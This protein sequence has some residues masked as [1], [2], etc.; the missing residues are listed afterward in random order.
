MLLSEINETAVT[1]PFD[2]RGPL[3]LYNVMVVEYSTT[4]DW[5]NDAESGPS[6]GG[7]FTKA[8][9]RA[10]DG[11]KLCWASRRLGIQP[12]FCWYH[13]AWPEK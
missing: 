6:P 4:K 13:S 12:L 10:Q 1:T 3:A 9:S 2:Y 8:S 11:K 7:L 5:L